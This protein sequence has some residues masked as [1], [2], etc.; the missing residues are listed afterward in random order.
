M[1][2]FAIAC[3]VVP[4]MV[5]AQEAAQAQLSVEF[6]ERR[7]RPLLA[8]NCYE[9]HSTKTG[10]E[11]GELILDS[12]GGLHKG[13]SRGTLLKAGEPAASLLWRAVSYREPELEMPPA[14]KLDAQ[15]LQLLKKWI[16]GGAPLPKADSRP[17]Q[18]AKAID[19]K[20][21]REFWSFQPL[22]AVPTPDVEKRW[23]DSCWPRWKP[24]A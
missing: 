5:S 23:T 12:A 9:C 4:V 24:M 20:K 19:F 11:N 17:V 2:L 22:K 16:E 8:K 1:L 13:G 15:D 14:G 18:S 21:G 3:C 10:P 7:I 6:F